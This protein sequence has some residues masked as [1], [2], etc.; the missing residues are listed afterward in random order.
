M[1]EIAIHLIDINS[2]KETLQIVSDGINA[3]KYSPLGTYLV[4]CC[5]HTK[6]S[7]NLS[8]WHSKTGDE[9]ASFEFK[10]NSKEGPKMVR[11]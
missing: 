6:G 11:S 5:K 9:L 8:V 10:N 7:K 1:D 4:G 2:G 3:I